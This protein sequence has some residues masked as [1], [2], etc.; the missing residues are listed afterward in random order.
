MSQ[1][2]DQAEGAGL[3]WAT[4]RRAKKAL[5]IK[6]SKST[7]RAGGLGSSPRR[8]PNLA[9]ML[10]F[11]KLVP[12]VQA[13]TFGPRRRMTW[14]PAVR[15]WYERSARDFC[16]LKAIGATIEPSGDRLL[17]RAGLK[18]IPGTFIRRVR[19]VKPELLALLHEQV[20]AFSVKPTLP[21][22]YQPPMM[23]PVWSNRARPAGAEWLNLTARSCT[24]ASHAAALPHLAVACN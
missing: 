15:R 12:S 20:A 8:C 9:N 14:R 23:N 24:S 22:S 5:G 10:K 17:L 18:P 2:K 6:S 4:V 1:I 3:S 11:Q 21:A 16:H 13:S 19:E 7:W